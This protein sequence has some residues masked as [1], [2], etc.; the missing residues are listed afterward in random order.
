MVFMISVGLE[1]RARLLDS[2]TSRA[3]TADANI[4]EKY[5]IRELS[6]ELRDIVRWLRR[7]RQ[8]RSSAVNRASPMLLTYTTA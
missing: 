7:L 6:V 4:H 2:A 1:E 5:S 8:K 3:Q